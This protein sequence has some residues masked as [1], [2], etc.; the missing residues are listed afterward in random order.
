MKR[1]ISLPIYLFSLLLIACFAPIAKTDNPTA[2]F[3]SPIAGRPL[4][5]QGNEPFP[6]PERFNNDVADKLRGEFGIE[7]IVFVERSVFQ[8]S[9]YYTDFIDG[10]R[11]FG[12]DICVLDLK[13]G[14]KRSILPAEMKS[15]IV[16][17]IDLSFDAKRV[18]FDWKADN[19]SG[20]HIWEIGID[21]TGLRQITF[22]SDSDAQTVE[23][24]KLYAENPHH[25][26][27][28]PERYPDYFGVYQRWTDDIHP[29]Y[30][31]DGGI[32]FASTRCQHGILCDGPDYLNTTVLYRTN[33]EGK[34]DSQGHVLLEKLTNSSVSEANPVVVQ[35]GRIIYTRWEY[36]DQ[37]ASCVKCVWS[38]K[39][40]GTASAEVFG[41]DH[42]S[43][44]SVIHAR[45]VPNSPQ[46]YVAT[47][48]PHCPQTGVGG[49][50][51]IDAG[52][53]IRLAESYW[54]ITPETRTIHEGDFDHSWIRGIYPNGYSQTHISGPLFADPYPI[55]QNSLICSAMLDTKALFYRP[56]GYGIY[57]LED[58][59]KTRSDWEGKYTQYQPFDAQKYGAPEE[60]LLR[61]QLL[62]RA[63]GTSCWSAIPVAPRP[64]PPINITELDENLASQKIH[65]VPAAACLV[66][67]VYAGME[68]V[69]RGEAKYIRINEQVPRPWSARRTWGGDPRR[70][71]SVDEYDQQHSPVGA[72]HLGLKVQWGIVPIE[73]DGSAW[74]LVP[75]DRNVF[76][77]VLDENFQELQRERT[78]V[79][80]RPGEVR[81]CVGC[82]EIQQNAPTQQTNSNP[83]ALRRAPSVPG[84]QPGETDGA[85]TLSFA[86][87]V[88]PIL[89]KK[90][91]SCHN[92]DYVHTDGKRTTLDLRGMTTP[93]FNVA[94]ENLLGFR[95][96]HDA[97]YNVQT[98]PE[99]QSLV[100]RVI[101]EIRP[102]VGNAEYLPA[103]TLGSTTAPLMKILDAGHYGVQLTLEE[104]VRIVTWIDSNCQY[105][106]SYIGAKNKRFESLPNYRPEVSFDKAISSQDENP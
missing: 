31:P 75:A 10:S 2:P 73:E 106:G 48:A 37:G 58:F 101:R 105:F 4:L 64:V 22:A 5:C 83:I 88:Q 86:A 51:G 69:E 59:N 11:F 66:T 43:P 92:G 42:A 57:F 77:Q 87:D 47:G 44:P 14:R 28:H 19:K 103:K 38:M 13:T 12:T 80:Y 30:L 70:N 29:A 46:M 27:S 61:Y 41:N 6:A 32:V 82:H 85:R 1:Q 15:G 25:W 50:I 71:S 60:Y 7:Q 54:P 90:C 24:Y 21:G 33:A 81:A 97:S 3:T 102:K 67:D 34:T 96:G 72:T 74:F 16:N 45:P 76:F 104:R 36:V 100:G 55:S 56:D 62:Y 84:P 91:V 68:N 65:G 9:H 52:K 39:Q 79:N 18:L 35:D 40:N 99:S 89:D 23:R 20:F 8:S 49:L 63:A 78:Y 17:R 53:N 94:Y 26:V 98:R 93:H 95:C